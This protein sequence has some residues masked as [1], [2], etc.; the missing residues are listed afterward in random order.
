[1]DIDKETMIFRDELTN[2]KFN[3]SRCQPLNMGTD[4]EDTQAVMDFLTTDTF[5]YIMDME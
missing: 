3:F 1:M 2:G 4:E 5:K